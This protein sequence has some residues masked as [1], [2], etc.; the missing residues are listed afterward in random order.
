MR[1]RQRSVRAAAE[2]KRVGGQR[3]QR[4]YVMSGEAGAAQK[5]K[6]VVA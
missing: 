1:E 6:G 3:G 2:E 5:G 4:G